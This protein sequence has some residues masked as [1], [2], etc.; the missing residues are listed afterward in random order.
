[1]ANRSD[2]LKT[3]VGAE[4]DFGPLFEP[5]TVNGLTL[6][7]RFVMPGMQRQW[8]EDGR[9]LP[10]LA[11][12]Y[13]RRVEGGVG[14]VITESCA[15]D[16]PSSTQTPM[17]ARITDATLDAWAACI[18]AV[19]NAGGHI[20]VQLWH[21]GAVRKEGG[22]G[23]YSPYRSL[24]PSGLVYA[25]KPNGLAATSEDLQAIREAFVR[26][27]RA[28]QQMGADGVEVHAC[29][30]YLLD[31]FLWAET[32]RRT[33][34]YGGDDIRARVRFPAEIVAGIRAAVGP[35][36]PISFRFS[37]WKEVNY[38]ARVA[39]APE[40]LRV[41]LADLRAAGADIFHA[42][43]RRFWVPEWPGSDLGIAGWTKSFTG[44]PVIAVGSVGVDTDVMENF[45][46][47]EAKATGETGFRELL[48]RFHNGEFDLISVGRGLIG[49]PDW[50]NKVRD[51]RYGDIRV[52]TKKDLIGDLELEGFVSD[53]HG[54]AGVSH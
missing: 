21:E 35:D 31:Q 27:A 20:F 49:D 15:V 51:G 17:F 19:K 4:L 42:S 24:S 6:P 29:H 46:G 30:G 34:G 38:E 40:D 22:D 53:A 11:Q 52:F 47:K 23:P 7:N 3:D 5:F 32:N 54:S 14:L 44:A 18:A 1:L 45:F 39:P 41:M 33:D 13:R 8:C 25:G 50:V 12:Y 26:G 48:R 16:H 28:A 43:A 2:S 37:Q 10:R 36:F 9:P